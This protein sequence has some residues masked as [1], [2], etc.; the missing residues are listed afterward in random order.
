MSVIRQRR[1]TNF[2]VVDNSSITD[3]R[4]SLRAKGLHVVLLSK[5]DHW[6]FSS[7]R[8]ADEC[9]EGRDAV[10]TAMRELKAAGYVREIREQGE[11]G[12]WTTVMEVSE[13]PADDIPVSSSGRPGVV[14]RPKTAS[15]ATGEPTYGEPSFGESGDKSKDGVANTESK[16]TPSVAL[17]AT[18]KKRTPRPARSKRAVAETDEGLASNRMPDDDP[19]PTDLTAFRAK[20]K[21]STFAVVEEFTR[22]AL[23]DSSVPAAQ[24]NTIKGAFGRWIK[25]QTNQGVTPEELLEAMDLFFVKAGSYTRPGDELWK[26]FMGRFAQLHTRA[27]APDITNPDYYLDKTPKENIEWTRE[28]WLAEQAQLRRSS[29]GRT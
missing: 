27:S 3:E 1:R 20:R 8:I 19:T 14:V 10:R 16:E 29:P 23:E 24:R 13:V 15:Q 26:G 25:K 17:R 6:E 18:V 2:T 9:V 12:F 28:R 21:P 4:L 11:G 7:D 5:P 22:R